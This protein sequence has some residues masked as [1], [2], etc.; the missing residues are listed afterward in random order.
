[1]NTI[2]AKGTEI[3]FDKYGAMSQINVFS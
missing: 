2:N 1:M 3:Q